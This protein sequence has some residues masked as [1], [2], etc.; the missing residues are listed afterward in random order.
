MGKQI[1]T[2]IFCLSGLLILAGLTLYLT[3]WNV[4]PWLFAI[5]AA[6]I[7][8]YHLI[9]PT[10]GL[11]VRQKRLQR[12]NVIGGIILLASSWFMFRHRTEWILGLT[13]AVIFMVYAAFVPGDK[14]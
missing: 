2:I 5:G 3:G 13:I 8:L 7:T 1:R 4:A 9:L 10:E 12:F 6:G 14:K 11:N